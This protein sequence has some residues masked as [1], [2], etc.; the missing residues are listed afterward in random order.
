MSKYNKKKNH[1]GLVTGMIIG[2]AAASVLFLTVYFVFLRGE[3]NTPGGDPQGTT[4][5]RETGSGQ[6]TEDVS[7]NTME[8]IFEPVEPSGTSGAET[9]DVPQ[10]D[11]KVETPYGTL[12]YPGKWSGSVRTEQADL[13]YGYAV[14][15][16]GTVNEQEVALFSVL[17]GHS[18]A[19]A[20]YI[21]SVMNGGVSTDVYVEAVTFSPDDSW[22]TA[23][24]EEI[25]AMQSDTDY[26]IRKLQAEPYFQMPMDE[27][28]VTVPDLSDAALET[29]YC[30]LY[31]PGE[32]KDA[33]SWEITSDGD[34][35]FVEFTG[36]FSGQSAA[37]FTVTFNEPESMG[38]R[39]GT[40]N[41]QG[42]EI[43]VCLTLCD[44]PQD[45]NWGDSERNLFL[46]L[47]EQAFTML[48]K[49]KEDSRYTSILD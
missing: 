35:C 46:T 13:G 6:E 44:F 26:L 17:F 27:E 29:P 9:T 12:Y 38:F 2:A 36:T 31:Y 22:N 7:G 43:A 19:D 18:S 4:D 14:H 10:E 37:I 41:D 20:A 45:A 39:M 1:T 48:E 32:W 40:L 11:M 47:Q 16:Y 33:V 15:F 34:I 49:L 21:G 25:R 24:A 30:T 23:D 42:R 28:T 5:I 8:P 3:A